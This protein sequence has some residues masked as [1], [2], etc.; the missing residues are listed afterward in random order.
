[1]DLLTGELK[2]ACS[3]APSESL[4]GPSARRLLNFRG[5]GVWT[6]ALNTDKLQQGREGH[7]ARDSDDSK[8]ITCWTAAGS[9][10]NGET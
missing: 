5:M 10:A 7:Q 4:L 1:M 8:K 6:S 3:Y 2:R 9:D